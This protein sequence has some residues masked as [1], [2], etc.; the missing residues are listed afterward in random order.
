MAN[1]K[2]EVEIYGNTAQFENSL[3]GINTAMTALK[4][5][6]SGLKGALKLDPTNTELMAKLQNNLKTQLEQTKNKASQLKSEISSVD[7]TTPDGQ[8]KFLQLS[9]DLQ[10]AETRAGYLQQDIKNLDSSIS[11]GKFNIDLKTDQ[12]ESKIEKIKGGF[13]A[14]KELAI[15]AVR[16]V[17]S[18]IVNKLSSSIGNAVKRFDTLEGYPKL[19]KQMGYST[20]DVSDSMNILKKGVDGLPTTL[21]DLTKSGQGFAI[22]QKNATAGA[23]TATALN[24]AFIA[25]NASSEDASRGV[26]QYSK[27][28]AS[29]TVELDS[30]KTLQETMPY[31]LNKVAGAFGLTGKTAERD[32]YAK[33]KDGSITMDQLNDKFIELDG[34]ANGFADTARTASGGIGTSFQNMS[35]SITNGLAETVTQINNALKEATGKGIAEHLNSLKDLFKEV[36]KVINEAIAET[37]PKVLEAL[38]EA[39]KKIKEFY[40][41]LMS[42]KEGAELLRSALVGLLAGFVAFKIV[43][44]II[45]IMKK[46]KTAFELAK[47]AAIL[48]NGAIAA[49]PV[50]AIIVAITAIVGALVYFFTQTKLGK[51]IWA[52]F[53]KWLQGAWEGIKDFFSGLGQWFKDLWQGIV[54]FVKGVWDGI[55]GFFGGIIQGIKNFFSGLGTWFSE[56]WQGIID[57]FTNIWNTVTTTIQN[58]VT[59]IMNFFKPLTDFFGAIFGLIGAIIELAWQ[60]IL[61]GARG[62]WQGITTVFSAVVGFFTPIFQAVA[63]FIGGVFSAIGQFA[64][65]AWNFIVGVFSA[66]VGWFGGVFNAVGQVVSAVFSAIGNF[67]SNAWNGIVSVFSA[68]GG[69]FSGIF[70][71]VSKAVSDVFNG[72][73]KFAQDAWNGI[74]GVFGSVGKWFSDIFDGIGKTVSNVFKGITDTIEKVT[75]TIS[76]ITDK[77]KGWFGGGSVVLQREFA[78]LK[79]RGLTQNSSSVSNKYENSF[80]INTQGNQDPTAIARAVRREFELG[81]A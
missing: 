62:L 58:V 54:D 40:D 64:S 50:M 77:V 73:G 18:A 3:K 69:W 78:D 60:L 28:L 66:V 6:A 22:I 53:I 17:G 74:T 9:R 34:G 43:Q 45:D 19:M 13:S 61:A 80:T 67:A 46:I 8:K 55:T 15:G 29:G 39:I 25:S 49:N 70:N 76:G 37:L 10:T 81:R 42:D 63:D 21:Q 14:F 41:W 24:D 30:W 23:K 12:A 57:F 20:D 35:S 5:E 11:G 71:G 4:S 26:E 51:K 68:I 38:G 16:E 47:N 72:F 48:F 79:A 56:L 36:F 59:N 27:M 33:L 7:K 31:A 44:T 75:G 32:L 52:D 65:N 1:A 2:F